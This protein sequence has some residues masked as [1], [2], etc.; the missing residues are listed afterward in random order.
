MKKKYINPSII[1]VSIQT[2]KLLESSLKMHGSGG[3]AGNSLAPGYFEDD[4][5]EYDD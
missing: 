2:A 1:M 4:D 3:N 5:E